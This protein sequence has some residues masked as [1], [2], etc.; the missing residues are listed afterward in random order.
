MTYLF[1]QHIEVT[2]LGS[3]DVILTGERVEQ[4]HAGAGSLLAVPSLLLLPSLGAV[5]LRQ[6]N[7]QLAHGRLDLAHSLSDVSRQQN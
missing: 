4:L 2:G 5:H 3:D 7:L 6:Q 1:L